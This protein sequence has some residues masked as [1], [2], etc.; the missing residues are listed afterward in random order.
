MRHRI[1]RP[2][3]LRGLRAFQHDYPPAK[4]YL[5]YGGER[6]WTEDGIEILPLA[7]AIRA[8]PGQLANPFT[9]AP[10]P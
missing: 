8:L 9:A 2:E 10:S 5:V 3:D 1:R 4:A 7:D 6:R